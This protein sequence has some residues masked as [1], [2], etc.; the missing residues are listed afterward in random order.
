MSEVIGNEIINSNYL[1]YSDF[2]SHEEIE[3]FSFYMYESD[4]RRLKGFEDIFG[5]FLEL[6]KKS[7]FGK[8]PSMKIYSKNY[9]LF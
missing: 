5:S 6:K 8:I 3:V 4:P 7:Q 1:D 2:L 9:T